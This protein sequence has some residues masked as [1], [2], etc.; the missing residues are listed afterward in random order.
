MRIR[1][2]RCLRVPDVPILAASL[3]SLPLLLVSLILATGDASAAPVF[4]V[5][6]TAVQ[7]D[8]T[9]VHLLASG[10]E[11][12]NRLHDARGFTVVRRP[13]DGRLVYAS[14]L[15]DR[16]VPTSLLP[17]RDDPATR[18]LQPGL[19]DA[20]AIGNATRM[21]RQ[22]V[23]PLLERSA[24]LFGTL[25]NLVLFIRFSDEDEFVE[26]ET[27]FES[28]FNDLSEATP[29]LRAY[30]RE[31]S[32]G[33]LDIVTHFLPQ[34]VDGA[35]AS[36]Q[37]SHPRAYYQPYHFK[38]NLIGYK[39]ELDAI[40][41]E[42]S[43]VKEALIDVIP[44]IPEDLVLDGDN[45]GAVDNVVVIV[46]GGPDGWSDLLWPHMSLL[47]TDTME[48][49]DLLVLSYNW[50]MVDFLDQGRQIGVLAHE[51]FHT[52]GAPDLYHYNHDDIS[53]I[54]PWDLM[55]NNGATPQHMSA[56]M[57]HRYG[58]W[59][60][61]IPEITVTGR[62]T[63]NPLVA[64]TGQAF[65]IGVPGTTRHFF[66]LE[67]RH[68][69]GVFESSLPGSGLLVHRIDSR[70]SGNASGPPDEVYTLRPGGSPSENGSIVDAPFSADTGR[71]T[72]NLETDPYPFLGDGT[73]VGLRISDV[74]EV[75][76]T[77]SF[78][79]CLAFQQCWQKDC[80][81]DGCGGVCGTCDPDQVCDAGLCS[82]DQGCATYTTCLADCDD[83]DCREW[84]GRVPVV[85]PAPDD[86]HTEATCN[87]TT[88]IC[89]YP[90]LDDGTP[91]DDGNACT[92]LDECVAGICTGSDPM[93]CPEAEGCF[94]AGTCS[95]KTGE[96]TVKPLSRGTDCNDGDSCTNND[97]CDGKGT[98]AGKA[99][100][101]PALPCRS[102]VAC[103]GEGDC[104]FEPT[105]L[106][107][108]CSDDDLCTVDDAC[109]GAGNCAGV[110]LACDP[111]LCSTNAGCEAGEC[112]F[113]LLPQG[114]G[115]DDGDPCTRDEIC[116]ADGT[117]AGT[118]DPACGEARDVFTP[119]GD[120]AFEP[121][122]NKAVS[123]GCSAGTGAGNDPGILFIML[124]AMF[125]LHRSVR[126][127]HN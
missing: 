92:R 106:G 114:T 77:I 14:R 28:M 105:A 75:G 109:D 94:A 6:V 58:Q 37:S 98:C 20:P 32:Y 123:S 107:E 120:D 59:I 51:M 117:C 46:S 27:M 7:P 90:V 31:A 39:D 84:C 3:L 93:L 11:F 33:Q 1:L 36:Y 64:P 29:S 110:P 68:A 48:I 125:M 50:L 55:E 99:Y 78:D 22:A 89:E 12:Y 122:P 118:L 112:V 34:P 67:Y 97:I 56:W 16:L 52:L 61:E 49:N 111:P 124:C 43:L 71:T 65:K 25:N 96:C 15:G 30:Y 121:K 115:C 88:G 116:D 2:L 17:G 5:P 41:R 108:T 79:V 42:Q 18:G 8:G 9:V 83:D 40:K 10:D 95:K 54:G 38:F 45:D 24:P 4:N 85:C 103:D 119:G 19:V 57:K 44:Q 69:E 126:R 102:A 100:E 113:D 35:I 76:E 60:D 87:T 81:D 127:N 101:C 72:L 104:T 73:K 91:C 70:R 82:E 66:I 21:A 26:P 23:G 86:C 13:D 53:P 80:G 63:L 62:Y 74:S 47:L